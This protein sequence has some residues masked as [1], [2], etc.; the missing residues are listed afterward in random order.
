MSQPENCQ[1][2]YRAY[3]PRVAKGRFSLNR[4]TNRIRI[5]VQGRL[6]PYQPPVA[7]PLFNGILFFII[8]RVHIGLGLTIAKHF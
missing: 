6:R 5:P 8:I 4:P 3:R 7:T 2:G 1:G